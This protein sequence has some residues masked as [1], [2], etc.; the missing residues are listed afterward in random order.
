MLPRDAWDGHEHAAPV[1]PLDL[2]GEL[3]RCA[4]VRP[5]AGPLPET[6]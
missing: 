5:A 3:W 4:N 2:D 1:E 6:D